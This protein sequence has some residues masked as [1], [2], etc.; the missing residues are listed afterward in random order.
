MCH[1]QALLGHVDGTV[2]ILFADHV[3]VS[4]QNH[5]LVVFHAAGAVCKQDHIVQGIL[6]IAQVV[7]PGKGHQI[8]ADL[9]GVAGTMGHG[10]DLLKIAK[11]CLR[12]QPGQFF[13]FH[14]ISL[15]DRQ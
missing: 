15:L 4:L 12:L 3:H 14:T 2:G 8:V 11:H 9:L 1:I 13:G 6:H 5:R 10:A 7:F